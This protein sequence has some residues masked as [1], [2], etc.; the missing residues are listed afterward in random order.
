[1]LDFSRETLRGAGYLP[2]YLYRQKYMSG[3]LENV[4]WCLPGKESVYNIIMME[5]LQTVVS[6]GGGGVTKLVDPGA[7]KIRRISN[8]KYPYD[9]IGQR[10]RWMEA[11]RAALSFWQ[12]LPTEEE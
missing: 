10:G 11:K 6:I 9:Y 4:G 7:G 2:Y 1:M 3:S 8:P 12:G 5:E